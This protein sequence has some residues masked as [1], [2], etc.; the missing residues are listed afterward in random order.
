[1]AP[2]PTYV[3]P[4]AIRAGDTLAFLVSSGDTP[5]D[6]GW[7]GSAKI[8]GPA[9]SG[10]AT[11][12]ASGSDF[13]VTFP[14]ATTTALPAGDYQWALTVTDGTSRYTVGEGRIRLEVNP[15][16]VATTDGLVHCQRTLTLIETAIEGRL[17]SDHE[18]YAIGGRSI[19]KIPIRELVRLRGIYLAKVQALQNAG[20]PRPST[21]AQFVRPGLGNGQFVRPGVGIV[22]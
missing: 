7:T 12:T 19:A 10:A 15:E 5:A 3:V 21:V 16:T 17:T 14:K 13:L 2:T 22:P 1:M 11:V 4:D 18:S 6:G 8:F 9:T 20:K